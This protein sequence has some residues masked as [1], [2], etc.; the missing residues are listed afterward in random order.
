MDHSEEHDRIVAEISR[1]DAGTDPFAAAVRATRMPMVITDPT[2]VDNPIVFANDAFLRL[3]GYDRSEIVGKNCRFLQGPKSDSDTVSLIRQAIVDKVPVELDL[4]NYKKSGETF[5]NRV[6]ISP[7]FDETGV[8]S[9]F[10]ASQL[11][12]TIEREKLVFL[13]QRGRDLEAQVAGRTAAL[14]SSEDQ[15]RFTLEAGELGYWTFDPIT[16]AVTL[17]DRCR[18]H[19]GLKP[20][21]PVTYQGL[22]ERILPEDR[23]GREK[24]LRRAIQNGH[25]YTVEYRVRWPNGEVHWLQIRGRSHDHNGGPGPELA[26]VVLDITEQKR[27]EEARYFLMRELNHRIKNIMATVQSIVQQTLR[28]VSSTALAGTTITA[29]LQSMAAAQDALIHGDGSEGNLRDVVEGTLRPFREAYDDRFQV[30]GPD[31]LIPSQTVLSLSMALHELT[32]NAIKYGALSNDK[33]RVTIKWG[34]TGQGGEDEFWLRWEEREGPP[35]S[36]PAN[37]GFGTRMIERILAANTSG[38]AN[39][40][41]QPEGVV[42][43]TSAPVRQAEIAS[44]A[45]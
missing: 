34:I 5:W 28:Q 15:L 12:V 1:S 40:T 33:G 8:L 4:L 43:E 17:S 31:V 36:P 20:D 9:Y 29:R 37:R 13:E 45:N 42:F 22:I 6:L 16:K 38:A 41:F 2:Q 30:N 7:V 25:D 23:E 35:V 11:D 27:G 32:T 3:T 21:E 24:A 26:G 44:I 10:F 18:Q 39:L 14:R 19:F